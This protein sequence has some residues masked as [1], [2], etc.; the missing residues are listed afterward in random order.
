[1]FEQQRWPRMAWIPLGAGLA[2]LWCAASFGVPG[3]FFSVVPGCLLL[4]AGVSTLLWPGDLRI[5]Q[6]VALGG[7]LG[8]PLALPAFVVAGFGTGLLLVVASAAAFVAA[9]SISVRQEPHVDEVPVPVPSPGLALQVAV[10]DLLLATMN[11]TL[12]MPVVSDR[13][14][15]RREVHQAR[16]QFAAAGWLE[17]PEGYH[18][19]P[20]PLE[21]P[22]LAPARSR[23]HAFEH[24]SF[25]SGYEPR[26][27]E[28]GRERWLSYAANRTAHAWVLRHREPRPWLV[29]IH[30]YQMGFPLADLF[31]FRP[32]WLHHRLGLNLLLPVLPLH[33][34]RKMGRRSGD[35]FLAADF[36]DTVHAEAQAMWDVR[37]LLSWVRAQGAPAVGVHGLSLG[38]YNTA[39]LASL[40]EGLACAI[41]GIPASDWTRIVWRHGPSLNIRHAERGGLVHDEVQELHRVVSPLVLE[42]KVPFEGRWIFGAVAD[43]LVPGDQVRDLWRHWG[44]PRITWYQGGHV[45]FR[46]H[47]EVGAMVEEALRAAGLVAGRA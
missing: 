33:G 35:G 10:D 15:I 1:M 45:T 43:R 18:L 38:G 2:W 37:R 46:A 3:F 25:E 11:L 17:K 24:L 30:G 6:F 39:L 8:V 22:Q 32:E 12:P 23:S 14:R 41:P 21:S 19:R 47:R 7:F 20:P 42:P 5:P 36:L 16:E 27:G 29:C 28:P 34:P 44:R 4:G 13:D 9:G 26:A 40:E 31:A